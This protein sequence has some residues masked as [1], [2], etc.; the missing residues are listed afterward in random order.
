MD[1]PRW[2]VVGASVRGASHEKSGQPCQDAHRWE[3][4]PDGVL[5]AA[6][7]DGAGSAALAEV[8]ATVAAR[9]AVE[10]A[11]RGLAAL[12][13]CPSREDGRGESASAAGENAGAC[14]DAATEWEPLLN[15]ALRTALAA[16]EA[17]AANR[18]AK[19][20]DLA[21]TLILVVA[22][23]DIVAAAQIGDGAAVV[24]DA[25]GA[26]K[27]LTAPAPSEYLNETIFLVSPGALDAAQTSVWRGRPAQLALFCDGLQMLAL[28]MPGAVPHAP[29]FA[30]LFRFVQS[31]TDETDAH[32]Q[33]E[34]FLCS[35]GVRQRSDDDV[36]LVLA[37]LHEVSSSS[38]LPPGEG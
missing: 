14:L 28:K 17:E 33:L 23:Q 21:C 7:A 25:E 6:I 18:E 30:P 10:S 8:G 31:A 22:T 35:P 5:V 3:V 2:R 11:I 24:A 27:S 12:T 13:A 34:A 16:V 37:S 19:P 1:Q 26:I 32:S 36:T 20:R 4:L 29:F 38:P 9:A 15:E